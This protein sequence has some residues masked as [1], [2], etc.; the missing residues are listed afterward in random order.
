LCINVYRNTSDDTIEQAQKV[1]TL[2]TESSNMIK[3]I[4]SVFDASVEGLDHRTSSMDTCD[5]NK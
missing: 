4:K 3:G 2:G 1:L 5:V